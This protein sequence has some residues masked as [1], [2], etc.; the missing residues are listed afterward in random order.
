MDRRDFIMRERKKKAERDGLPDE[1]GY[2]LEESFQ[3]SYHILRKL[4]SESDACCCQNSISPMKIKHI[5]SSIF[6]DDQVY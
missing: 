1:E 5:K 4:K 3:L 2:L 6:N